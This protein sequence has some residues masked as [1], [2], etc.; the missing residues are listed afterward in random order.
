M[1]QQGALDFLGSTRLGGEK[2]IRDNLYFSFST[3]FCSLNK[4]AQ[5]VETTTFVE[6]LGGKLEYRFPSLS[7]QVGREPPASALSC[8][9][10]GRGVIPTPS[11]WGVSLSRSWRF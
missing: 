9:R 5:G 4:D 7:L 3:G 1:L 2:Q 10:L 8:G 6:G 11:Q